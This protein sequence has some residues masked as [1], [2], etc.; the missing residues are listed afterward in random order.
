MLWT[1]INESDVFYS[2]SAYPSAGNCIRSSNPFDY[3]RNGYFLDNAS[4][5]VGK[6]NVNFN[7]N[8]SSA[9]TG[10]HMD[11]PGV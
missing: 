8:I 2:P 4:L 7:S 9:G 5:F 1:V 3:I 6:D 10:V 11:I